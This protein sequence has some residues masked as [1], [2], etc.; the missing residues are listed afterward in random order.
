[1][2]QRRGDLS[3]EN[4]QRE[5]P[6]TDAHEHASSVHGKGVALP[7][8]TGQRLR[9]GEQ[10]AGVRR[11]IAAEIDSLA[12]LRYG[13]GER[14]ARFAHQQTQELPAPLLKQL[15]GPLKTRG[16]LRGRGRVPLRL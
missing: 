11:V 10:L 3:A 6:R 1:G 16:A 15:R 12:Q 13:V 8:R 5:V 2:R 4:G 9:R 14:L 7:G